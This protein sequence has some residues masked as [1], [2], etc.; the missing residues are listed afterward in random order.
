MEI[1]KVILL[2]IIIVT[3]GIVLKKLKKRLGEQEIRGR[4]DKCSN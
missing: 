1:P 2:F 4:I 3:L